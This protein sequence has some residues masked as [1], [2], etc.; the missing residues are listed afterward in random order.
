MSDFK[1]NNT[2]INFIPYQQYLQPHDLAIKGQLL[3]SKN[4]DNVSFCVLNDQMIGVSGNF[5][6][7][8]I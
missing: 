7:I 1:W 8:S 4:I 3:N 6:K 5:W 2:F